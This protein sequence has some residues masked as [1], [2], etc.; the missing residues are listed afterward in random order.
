MRKIC[1]P[2]AF[3]SAGQVMDDV[4][5]PLGAKPLVARGEVSIKLIFK[6]GN[7]LSPIL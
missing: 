6:L 2:F 1:D 3:F 7:S 5:I 4:I